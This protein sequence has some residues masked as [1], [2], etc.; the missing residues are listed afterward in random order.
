MVLE[1]AKNNSFL[2]KLCYVLGT[3][4]WVPRGIKQKEGKILIYTTKLKF[5]QDSLGK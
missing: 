4:N 5:C 2:E 3:N 1:R